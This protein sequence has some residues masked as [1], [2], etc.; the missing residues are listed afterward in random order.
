[1]KI[2]VC[3]GSS[4]HVKGSRWVVEDLQKLIAKHDLEGKVELNGTFCMGQ[5]QKGVCVKLDDTLY[6][7][8]PSDTE[9]FF[10]EHILGKV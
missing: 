7:V 2:T 4:C 9:A 6:S 10:Q 1:M 8:S 5:C 3:I